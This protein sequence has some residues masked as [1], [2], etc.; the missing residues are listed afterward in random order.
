MTIIRTS[1]YYN[2]T[3]SIW[4]FQINFTHERLGVEVLAILCLVV[5]IVVIDNTMS[6]SRCPCLSRDLHAC[7]SSLQW[8]V[9]AY[10]LPFAG[11]WLAAECCQID[12]A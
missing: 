5:I 11:L 9:D 8:I 12:L 4:R 6:T 2:G 10:S 1:Y 3:L 7:R